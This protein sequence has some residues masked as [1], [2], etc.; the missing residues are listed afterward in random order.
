MLFKKQTPV[1]KGKPAAAPSAATA[2]VNELTLDF[3]K[4]GATSMM[5]TEDHSAGDVVKKGILKIGPFVGLISRDKIA[6]K[7]GL[8][9]RCEFQVKALQDSKNGLPNNF[10]IGP[11]PRD[12][13]GNVLDWWKQQRPI[14]VSEKIRKGHVDL[15]MPEGTVAVHIGILGNW[16]HPGPAGNGQI[17]V[18]WMRLSR[19]A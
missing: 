1:A 9:Y 17:G 10:F 19:V 5:T 18:V 7:P 14:K 4:L 3:S 6:T 8:V 2:A 15:Q 11:V 13:K 16:A 12:E